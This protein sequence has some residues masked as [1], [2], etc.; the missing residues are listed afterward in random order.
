MDVGLAEEAVTSCHDS[1]DKTHIIL[2]CIVFVMCFFTELCIITT[3]LGET[4]AFGAALDTRCKTSIVHDLC[5]QQTMDIRSKFWTATGCTAVAAHLG[6]RTSQRDWA[7][8]SRTALF[9]RRPVV[10]CRSFHPKKKTFPSASWSQVPGF[11][12]VKECTATFALK[13]FTVVTTSW[14]TFLNYYLVLVTDTTGCQ[15]P[16][17]MVQLSLYLTI[18]DKLEVFIPCFQTW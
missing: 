8:T 4:L 11:C 3:V 6:C 18:L 14:D 12:A 2:Y 16:W 13:R 15:R 17:S 10:P 5:S 1:I 7:V 9:E